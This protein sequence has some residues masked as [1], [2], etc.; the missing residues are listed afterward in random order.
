[1]VSQKIIL[2]SHFLRWF[3]NR[4]KMLCFKD[5]RKDVFFK[6]ICSTEMHLPTVK[7]RTKMLEEKIVNEKDSKSSVGASKGAREFKL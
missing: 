2:E 6:K 1:M 5:G 7:G 3:E 4:L